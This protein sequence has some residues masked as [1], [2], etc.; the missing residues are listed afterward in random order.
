MFD[1]LFKVMKY[2]AGESH[3]ELENYPRSTGD[4]IIV[5]HDECWG[6]E[7]LG[8]ILTANQILERLD[9]QPRWFIPYF[10]FARHDRRRDKE[11]GLELKIAFEMM[12]GLDIIT[13]DPHSDVLA[14]EYPYVPQ[15]YI[16]NC[17]N[18]KYDCIDGNSVFVIPD[19]G[20]TKKAYE[21]LNGRDHAQG[22]KYR[23]PKTG[24]LT[25]FGVDWARL[26]GRNCIVVDDICDGGG[27]FCGLG[28][29]LKDKGADTLTLIVTH[30]LFTQGLDELRKYYDYIY[31]FGKTNFRV[32][33]N[34]TYKEVSFEDNLV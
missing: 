32:N 17:I 33:G 2:P 30:G 9:I 5:I 13:A 14:C 28:Q 21:W 26:D 34:V 15:G 24:K 22:Q 31:T 8:N 19:T 27:T 7:D 29:V 16:L 6:F 18:N 20:A 1:E 3:I 25:G 10:P 11:D 4:K 12:K 23:D